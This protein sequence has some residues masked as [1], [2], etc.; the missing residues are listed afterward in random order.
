MSMKRNPQIETMRERLQ[1]YFAQERED[2]ILA[3]L[4]HWTED[5]LKPRMENGSFRL[6]PILLL[7]AGLATFSAGAFLF[8]SFGHP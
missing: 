8:F 6:N 4:R 2:T 1:S 5:P 3:S 7:L